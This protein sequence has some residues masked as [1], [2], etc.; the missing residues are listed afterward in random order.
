MRTLALGL[1]VGLSLGSSVATADSSKAWTAAKKVIPANMEMVGGVNAASAHNS[2]LYQALLPMAIAKAGDA[3]GE[4]DGIKADCGIDVINSIDSVVFGL[5]A[6]QKGT[7]VIAFRGVT[8][9]KLEACLV[10][11]AKDKGKT[12]KVETANGLTT[13]SGMNDKMLFTRWIGNDV[14]ALS[15]QPDDKDSTIAATAGGVTSDRSLHGLAAVNTGASLWLVTNKSSDVPADLG[16]GKMVGAYMSANLAA[17][18]VNLDAHVAV[19]SPAT[20]T[21]VAT[22]STAQL[23]EMTKPN[24]FTSGYADLLKTVRVAAA[25]SEVLVTAQVPEQALLGVVQAFVH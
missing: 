5:D 10:R 16:G 18:A 15:T 6:S 9:Q 24:S 7:M 1:L 11:R 13:Y 3:T 25:A 19:D 8:R 17:G 14:V 12:L 23:V 21:T 4:L 22:K 20:A 2:A